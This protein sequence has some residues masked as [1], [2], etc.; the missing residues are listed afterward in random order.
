MFAFI[1]RYPIS[2][3]FALL[4]H[5][6]IFA[7]FVSASL[8]DEPEVVKV[9]LVGDDTEAIRP[10][11]KQMEPMR[12]FAVDSSLVQKQ[13]ALLKEQEKAKVL[14]QKQ[15]EQQVVDDKKR[16]A[17]LQR[18]Q[19]TE[20]RRAEEARK[21]AT[22][23]QRKATEAKRLADIER[24]KV[25]VQKKRAEEEERRAEQARKATQLA[26]K[27]RK[28]ADLKVADAQK[29][30]EA[31]EARTKHLQAEIKQRVAE[32]QQ[33]E[34]QTA[35]ARKQ[36]EQAEAEAKLQRQLAAADATKRANIRQQEMANLREAYIA[37]IRA[38]VIS[39]W[40]TVARISPHAQCTLSITQTRKGEIVRAEVLN[41]TPETSPQFKR[42]AVNAV[43]RSA[44]LPPPQMEELFE[45]D[46]KF[47]F[48]P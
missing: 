36:R 12:T 25:V 44:P 24:Q 2:S 33:L 13:L 17:D 8:S 27:Q 28:E 14:S 21:K 7:S 4:L 45:S 40:R 1:A 30:R 42:D 48:K 29:Q 23:E 19:Q 34:Q 46:I 32:K 3:F 35:V 15:L 22:A 20:A 37:S 16:L 38:R 10:P 26:E 43:R 18:Q 31:E 47:I 5:V 6:V 39:N 11:I 41:C 9:S